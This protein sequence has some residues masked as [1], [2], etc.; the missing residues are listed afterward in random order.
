MSGRDGIRL[1]VAVLLLAASGSGVGEAAAHGRG[2][3]AGAA[4]DVYLAVTGSDA[5]DGSSPGSALATLQEA[6]RRAGPG[7]IVHVLPGTYVQ[8]ARRRVVGTTAAPIVIRGEGGVPVFSGGRTERWGLWLEGSTGVVLER[9]AFR[10]Y[11]DMGLLVVG[12]RDVTLRR[13]RVHDNGFDAQIGW[14]EGYGMHLDDSSDLLVE[15]N[16]VYR[17]GP[18]PRAPDE[19]GTGINGYALRRAVIRRNRSFD[20]NGGGILVEDSFDV[21]VARNRIH[22][23]DLD[24]S[25]DDWWDGGIWVDGGADVTLAGNRIE[26]NLG[27][28]IEIS[29]EDCQEPS[30]Y[31]LRNN[32]STGNYFGIFVWN[33]GTSAFPPARVLALQGNDFTGNTRRDVWIEGTR[34]DCRSRSRPRPA[35]DAR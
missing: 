18:S 1:F 8:S 13:L 2:A 16:R 23:N 25:V 17:N 14:V 12:S 5:A 9:L 11:T 21:L 35:Q 34:S 20:N 29:D 7:T 31:L 19:V 4:A 33:F 30:G 27:P 24:V 6:L 15:R 26:G 3:R 22:G 32:V 10:D 28:G